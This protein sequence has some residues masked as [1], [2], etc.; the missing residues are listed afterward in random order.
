VRRVKV[1]VV[2]S[3]D[4][5]PLPAPRAAGDL[6]PTVEL[7]AWTRMLLTG[8]AHLI[9]AHWRLRYRIEDPRPWLLEEQDPEARLAMEFA[10]AVT[11][12]TA[13][14]AVD[15]AL[16]TE[17]EAYRAEIAELLERRLAGRGLGVRIER[18]EAVALRPP[19][20]VEQ[21]F[22]LVIAAENERGASLNAARGYAARAAQE[23]RGEAARRIARA[24]G[25]R[26]RIVESAR[27]DADYF[28]RILPA[29]RERPDFVRRTLWQ[30]SVGR[31]LARVRDRY[32]LPP[33][34]A[35]RELRVWL[36]PEARA[37]RLR[38]SEPDAPRDP[39]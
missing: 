19:A 16:R 36:G 38:R 17:V 1:S 26:R 9:R 31:T 30:E 21:A 12:V 23:A 14:R 13:A 25:E 10:H 27:A 2:R 4:H 20:P 18:V 33:P 5:L 29:Y 28:D 35:P 8:D 3:I 24:E 37:P 6:P 32:V 11:R 7:D 34:G 22:E 39:F 15:A